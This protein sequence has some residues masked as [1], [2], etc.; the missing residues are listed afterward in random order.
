[1]NLREF[2]ALDVLNI[3]STQFSITRPDPKYQGLLETEYS[4]TA[5]QCC[6]VYRDDPRFERMR[7]LVPELLEPRKM[8]ATFRA[9]AAAWPRRGHPLVEHAL[10]IA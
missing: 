5:A 2:I 3:A 10:R 1:M 4:A 7:E 8:A 9:L 6:E